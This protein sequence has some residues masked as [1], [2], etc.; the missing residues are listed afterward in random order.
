MLFGLSAIGI[1]TEH[2]VH[3]LIKGPINNK[4]VSVTSVKK[5]KKKQH[6]KLKMVQKLV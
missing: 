4:A 1:A 2:Q 3:C 5:S 6:D